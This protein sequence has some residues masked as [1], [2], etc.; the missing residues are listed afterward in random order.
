MH[1]GQQRRAVLDYVIPYC[2][3]R[4]AFRRK[5]INHRQAVAFAV[6]NLKIELDAM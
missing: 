1:C 5:P 4:I 3:T 2:N 6:A